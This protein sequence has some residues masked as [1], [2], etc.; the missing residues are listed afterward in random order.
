MHA[1]NRRL[2]HVRFD[3]ASDA[4]LTQNDPKRPIA[5]NSFD[6]ATDT[7]SPK[8][9]QAIELMAAGKRLSQVVAESGVSRKTLY[10]WR[11]ETPASSPSCAPAVGKL[12]DGAADRLAALLPRASKCSRFSS[13]I[14]PIAPA[15]TPATAI[16]RM[17]NIKELLAD[18][19]QDGD[20]GKA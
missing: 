13:A 16:L 17:A 18:D 8:Q 9:W 19:D 2:C 20:T 11:H 7:L 10:R 15:S 4:T 3:P 1:R 5:E 12:Y 14:P 6:D